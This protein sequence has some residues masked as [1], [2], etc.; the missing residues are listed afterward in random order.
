MKAGRLV[1]RFF[2]SFRLR[3]HRHLN[4]FQKF[5]KGRFVGLRIPVSERLLNFYRFLPSNLKI[6]CKLH[7]VLCRFISSKANVEKLKQITSAQR[8]LFHRDSHDEC[9]YKTEFQL[10]LLSLHDEI[11]ILLDFFSVSAFPTTKKSKARNQISKSII[12]N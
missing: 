9:A 4:T 10:G 2:A 5:P 12:A 8:R 1:H 6:N 7:R 11:C 3:N